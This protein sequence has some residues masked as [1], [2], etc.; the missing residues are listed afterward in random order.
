MAT[1]QQLEKLHS[2]KRAFQGEET[3]ESAVLCQR[4]DKLVARTEHLLHQRSFLREERRKL[5][6]ACEYLDTAQKAVE[7][8][9][10]PDWMTVP[11]AVTAEAAEAAAKKEADGDS[12][13]PAA[14]PV[15]GPVPATV[16]I[17]MSGLMFEASVN[18]MR[19]DKGSALA[20]LSPYVPSSS[21][22]GNGATVPA[23]VSAA[24]TAEPASADDGS[25][26]D[27]GSLAGVHFMERDWWLFRYVLAFLRDGTLPSET[28][29]L[30]ALYREAAHY[31]LHELQLAIE[32]RKLHLHDAPAAASAKG[33]DD[34]GGKEAPPPWWQSLPSWLKAVDAV[35]AAAKKERESRPKAEDWWKDS[36]YKGKN[37]SK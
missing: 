35:E 8:I 15:P 4:I 30:V 13:G 19:R 37:Y 29:L 27:P 24:A 9:R 14:A 23:S 32:D 34:K 28:P 12:S 26:E 10:R 1:I 2:I 31:D 6:S 21:G 18:A 17:N 25:G 20:K 5:R 36:S 11:G 7:V 16:K 22:S 3:L 33:K